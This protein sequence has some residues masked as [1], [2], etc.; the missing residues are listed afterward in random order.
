MRIVKFVCLVRVVV[1]VK[2]CQGVEILSV[3]LVA[4][5]DLYYL[6]VNE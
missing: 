6:K 5:W 3:E 1:F 4:L 2:L